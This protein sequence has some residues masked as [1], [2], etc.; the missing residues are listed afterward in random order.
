[1]IRRIVTADEWRLL[2]RRA[3]QKFDIAVAA[4]DRR[5]N[6]AQHAPAERGD[7]SGD[8]VADSDVNGSI[9]HDAFLDERAASFELRLDQRDELCRLYA[10]APVP[11]AEPI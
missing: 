5:R 3:Q 2:A 4:A 8:I 10:R 7:A 6:K 11:A 1:M 9:A